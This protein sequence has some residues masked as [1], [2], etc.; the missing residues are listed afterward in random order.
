MVERNFY[1]Y[2]NGEEFL[3]RT[4]NSLSPGKIGWNVSLSF[5]WVNSCTVIF[6]LKKSSNLFKAAILKHVYA[7]AQFG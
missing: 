6:S 5:L 4:L 3:D 2:I 7:C 1:F